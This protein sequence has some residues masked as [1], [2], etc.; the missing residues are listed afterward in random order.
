MG[1]SDVKA[2]DDELVIF[3]LNDS[4]MPGRFI[5]V[6]A[7]FPAVLGYTR[8][9]L[10]EKSPLDLV[11]P[12]QHAQ[13][14]SVTEELLR[15]RRAE[16]TLEFNDKSCMAHAFRFKAYLSTLNGTDAAICVAASPTSDGPGSSPKH[17]AGMLHTI[18]KNISK[19]LAP[20]HVASELLRA[21]DELFTWDAAYVLF[22]SE[23]HDKI[24]SLIYLDTIEG[25]R[26]EVPPPYTGTSMSRMTKLILSEGSRLILRNTPDEDTREELIRFGNTERSS[27]SLMFVPIRDGKKNVGIVSVQS[28]KMHHYTPADLATLQLLADYCGAALQRTYHEERRQRREFL[29]SKFSELGKELNVA[30]SPRET[31]VIILEIAEELFGWD[32]AYII[33]YDITEAKSYPVI[34]MDTIQGKR[35]EV[36]PVCHNGRATS[37]EQC[38]LLEGKKLVLRDDTRQPDYERFIPFGDTS[39]RSASLMF[40]PIR[41]GDVNLGVISIQSYTPYKYDEHDLELFQV[42]A[43]HCSGALERTRAEEKLYQEKLL[44]VKFAELG[45]KLAATTTSREAAMVILDTADDLFGWDACSINLYSEEDD[46][47]YL[48]L[49]IDEIDGKRT[50]VPAAYEGTQPTKTMRKILSNSPLL[51]LRNGEEEDDDQELIPFGDTT[52]RSAS[53][54]FVPLIKEHKNLGWISIQSY[55]KDYYTE[56]N[57]QTLQS[58]AD[59]CVGALQR[60]FAE[61]KLRENEE[62]LRLLTEQIPAFLWIVDTNMIFTACHGALLKEIHIVLERC[63]GKHIRDVSKDTCRELLHEDIHERV[64]SGRSESYEAIWNN[65]Y[66]HAYIEPLRDKNNTIIGCLGVAYDITQRKKAEE[67]LRKAHDELER[68]VEERTRELS[69]SNIM[70]KNEINDRKNA[71]EQ[72]A[73]SL[74]LLRAT[75]ESTTDGILVIAADSE[76]LTY[77]RTFI[78]MWRVPKDL[79]VSCDYE[80]I[81]DFMFEQIEHPDSFRN[82]TIEMSEQH[83]SESFDVLEF[84]DGRI[85]E[86][87]SKPQRIAGKTVGRVWSFR[88]VTERVKA[89]NALLQSESIYRKAIENA[90]GVPYSIIFGHDAYQFVGEGVKELLGIPPEE[91]TYSRLVQMVRELEIMDPEA[92][93]EDD[94]YVQAFKQG[95]VDKYRAD[96]CVQTPTGEEKWVSDCSVPLRDEETGAIIGSLGILQ[97]ITDRKRMEEALARSEKIY[98]EAIE[99]ASGVPYKAYFVRDG[100][101]FEY[102]YDFIGDGF[103]SLFG[104]PPEEASLNKFQLVFEEGVI[105]DTEQYDNLT[106]YARAFNRGEIDT[107]R[108]DFRIRTP[109]GEEKWVSDSSVPIIEQKSGDIIGSLGILQDITERKQAEKRAR[110]HREQLIQADK[111]VALGIL[112]SGIAHEINNPNNFIML[113]TPVLREAWSSITPI[114]EHYYEENGDFLVGGLPY[115]EMRSHIPVLF[116]GI[117]DGSTRINNIVN[118]LKNFARQRP[119]DMTESVDINAVART[120]VNLVENMI[121]QST[122]SFSLYPGEN[123]PLIKGNFQQ[124]EQVVINLIQNACQALTNRE[125]AITITTQYNADTGSIVLKVQDEGTG[126]SGETLKYIMDPFYTTKRDSGGTGLGLSISS[127][128]VSDHGGT[129]RFSSTPG[130]G[131]TATVTL[132]AKNKLEQEETLTSQ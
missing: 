125:S 102:R 68:H 40:A 61:Q 7:G 53:L 14:H 55:T 27:A 26:C 64:L 6:T 72:L 12:E 106:E 73:R 92:P 43:D 49:N 39:R 84:K 78:R 52:K 10:L 94:A 38:A 119:A 11:P 99:N 126:I 59:H 23:E 21:A 36:S 69:D 48:V 9:E 113:N 124:L 95:K 54:M 122:D 24:L 60:I 42:L 116:S 90:S 105:L 128:I 34:N 91:F 15:E 75:L 65:R 19:C 130:K 20:K 101:E 104:F 80:C 63:I 29:S 82:K 16:L 3:S 97:D 96:I 74:S 77:N 109:D 127:S 83:E 17:L 98:R 112:V 89:E 103:E 22:C 81:F 8:E 18:G 25:K 110:L 2:I 66:L 5:D 32:A 115:E 56:H 76:I 93:E 129:M 47:D 50:L 58:L 85:F 131:T 79:L 41:K 51:I 13:L 121:K 111:M 33:Y 120:A 1:S 100:R 67:Q 4:G 70:L 28:Y 71:E 37:I 114:L 45:K 87:Y 30:T 118:E 46:R 44:S 62:Q 117:L 88:D 57:L 108:V 107:F 123:I 132:P 35:Q 31:A 86:C